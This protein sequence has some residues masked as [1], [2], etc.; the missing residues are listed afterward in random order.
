MA[1]GP[2]IREDPAPVVRNVDDP[3]DCLQ[4]ER[5]SVTI[6]WLS[7]ALVAA[8]VASSDPPLELDWRAP[9]S[10]PDR[11]WALERLA[12]DGRLTKLERETRVIVRLREDD[13]AFVADLRTSQGEA[14]GSRALEAATCEELAEAVIVVLG[15]ALVPRP[16]DPA[17]PLEK[18]PNAGSAQPSKVTGPEAA[19]DSS[20]PAEAESF[21]A[22]E[23]GLFLR[24][25]VGVDRGS[26]PSA[27]FGFA[28]T[29]GYRFGAVALALRGAYWLPR[30]APAEDPRGVAEGA[31]VGGDFSRAEGLLLA[32]WSTP[33]VGV[34]SLEGC[35]GAGA[36]ALRAVGYGLPEPATE[37]RYFGLLAAELAAP[38]RL[39]R[40]VGL[41]LAAGGLVP[42]SREAY[43][44]EGLGHVFTPAP[45]GFRAEIASEMRF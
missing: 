39:S 6:S 21:G 29:G 23:S 28:L 33:P 13:G 15:M 20:E 10:C 16:N 2:E 5:V 3:L 27:T 42:L 18:P 26:L 24:A 36:A 19:P 14:E 1:A 17:E 25:G 22:E 43:A 35:L 7:S 8:V 45:F 37:R 41:R 40:R 34:T 44:I 30:S 9:A 4:K 31:D 38:I 11:A 12:S 32:C